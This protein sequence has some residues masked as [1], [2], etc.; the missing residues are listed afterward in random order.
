L[1][2]ARFLADEKKES[3]GGGAQFRE[4]D[5]LKKEADIVINNDSTLESLNEKIKKM[6]KEIDKRPNW[7]EYFFGILEAVAKRATCDRGKTAAIVT[8][9]NVILA[10][11]YVGSP[12]GLPQCDEV[13]HL[14]EK[15]IHADG[16]ER[17][18]CVRTIH[19]EQNAIIQAANNGVS[20]RGSKMYMKLE[21]C[22][23]CANMIVNA[24]IAEIVCL[25]RYHAAQRSREILKQGKVKVTIIDEEVEKY[26]N[27]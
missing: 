23:V 25:K 18:H 11:G 24:G 7:D 22:P 27:M 6:L 16:V 9:D 2:Y 8:R 26:K 19:A 20:L 3:K 15:T 12:R 4:F 5:N 1:T 21:P 13:G 14:Y 17:N 10:T